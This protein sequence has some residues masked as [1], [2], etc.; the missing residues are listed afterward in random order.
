[1]DK[2]EAMVWIDDPEECEQMPDEIAALLE[3]MDADALRHDGR[4]ESSE[5][6]LSFLEKRS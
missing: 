6:E 3:E 2:H 1:M 5:K 4:C